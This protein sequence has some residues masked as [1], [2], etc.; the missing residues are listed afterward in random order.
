VIVI[1]DAASGQQPGT[2]VALAGVRRGGCHLLRAASAAL[3]PAR[4]GIRTACGRF[5]RRG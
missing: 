3:S 5:Y 2:L 4:N 1:R